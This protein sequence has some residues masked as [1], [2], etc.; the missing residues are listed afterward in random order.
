VR[1]SASSWAAPTITSRRRTL[2]ADRLRV[3]VHPG[4]DHLGVT[5]SA[6]ALESAAGWLLAV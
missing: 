2:P 6:E 3:N 1:R 5:T 4:L